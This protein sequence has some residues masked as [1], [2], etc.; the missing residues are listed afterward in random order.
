MGGWV[1]RGVPALAAVRV[2]LTDPRRARGAPN[3]RPGASPSRPPGRR[4]ELRARGATGGTRPTPPPHTHTLA[5]S[6]VLP[7]QTC[8]QLAGE[9]GQ[10]TAGSGLTLRRT[11][12][13]RL[14]RRAAVQLQ[15]PS[16]NSSRRF[17][18]RGQLLLAATPP[19]LTPQLPRLSPPAGG[20]RRDAN[21]RSVPPEASSGRR[22]RLFGFF[23]FFFLVPPPLSHPPFSLF[24]L[25]GAST[26]PSPPRAR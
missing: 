21:L 10:A 22:I 1:G 20:R 8:R 2:L 18:R 26:P 14:P 9:A 13:A 4:G 7:P 24:R 6:A 19:M 12:G 15:S 5:R 11:P 17:G 25:R 16:S 23:F 3:G